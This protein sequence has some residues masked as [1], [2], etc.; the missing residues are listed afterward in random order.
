M[1][2]CLQ[3]SR[4]SFQVQ[5][6]NL[7]WLFS[8]HLI[9]TS[10]LY[11]MFYVQF[12]YPMCRDGTS[13]KPATLCLPWLSLSRCRSQ[14]AVAAE[15]CWPAWGQL[16]ECISLRRVKMSEEARIPAYRSGFA[17]LGH[18]PLTVSTLTCLLSVWVPARGQ[19]CVYAHAC[20][21]VHVCVRLF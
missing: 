6:K 19:E 16:G 1:F 2:L 17:F 4:I 7:G 12:K 21:R 3:R 14:L 10:T 5:Q 8:K 18:T 13:W 9:I 15:V 20:G 11:D